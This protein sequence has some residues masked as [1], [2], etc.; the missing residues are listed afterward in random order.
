MLTPERFSMQYL[1]WAR[2]HVLGEP[3]EELGSRRIRLSY[4][5]ADPFAVVLEIA[6]R[7]AW[8]RWQFARDLLAAGLHHGTGLGEVHVC[9][10]PHE[11]GDRVAIILRTEPGV[12]FELLLRRAEIEHALAGMHALVPSGQES[13]RIDWERE[14]AALGGGEQP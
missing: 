4:D 3:V 13:A 2:R 5:S 1:A 12:G 7:D 9:P 10:A 6:N 8:A 14:L 11:A